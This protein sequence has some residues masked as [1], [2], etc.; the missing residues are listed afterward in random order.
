MNLQFDPNFDFRK[1]LIYPF[2]RMNRRNVN[3]KKMSGPIRANGVDHLDQTALPYYGGALVVDI[4]QPDL[5]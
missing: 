2:N 1:P 4:F 5:N 3:A